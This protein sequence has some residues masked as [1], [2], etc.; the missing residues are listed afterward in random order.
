MDK[1]VDKPDSFDD[2]GFEYG[3][4]I[5]SVMWDSIVTFNFF[6]GRDNIPALRA[7]PNP[8]RLERSDEDGRQILHPGMEGDYPLMRYV[9]FTFTRDFEDLY[10]TALGGIAPVLRVEAFYA[11]DNTFEAAPTNGF[12]KLDEVRYAIGIDW[13][14]KLKFLNE[15]DAF[16][17]SPQFFHRKILDYPSYTLTQNG[18]ISVRD[19][20]YAT[21]LMVQTTYF[22][23][24]IIPSFFWLRDITEKANLIKV[25]VSYERSDV[26]NYTLGL[27][28]LNGGKT[29]DG[30]QAL[31]N[32]DQ[33]Y[34]TVGYR[35]S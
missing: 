18:G 26:W 11:F 12:K 34:F 30:F 29:G 9:G 14:V 27:L 22:H 33:V 17:V 20:N 21:S 15:R 24:K 23:N 35:F 6:Y 2:D 5:R 16:M 10:I 1:I 3:F 4:R 25:Q 7:S 8:P 32:K 13:R 31:T 28:L 19:D